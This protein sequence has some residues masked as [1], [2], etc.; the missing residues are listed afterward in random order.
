MF[1]LKLNLVVF[2]LTLSFEHINFFINFPERKIGQRMNT[3]YFGGVEA[4][5]TWT[6]T[7]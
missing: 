3:M 5:T 2:T 7:A 4:T 6:V 1:Y